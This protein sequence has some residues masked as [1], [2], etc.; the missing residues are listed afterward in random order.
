MKFRPRKKITST[1][2]SYNYYNYLGNYFRT[3]NQPSTNPCLTVNVTDNTIEIENMNQLRVYHN[4]IN[5]HY[6]SNT[7]GY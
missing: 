6:D 1:K 5:T 4:F 7:S 2:Y 3:D